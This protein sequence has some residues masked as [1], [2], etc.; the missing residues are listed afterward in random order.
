MVRS[1]SNSMRTIFRHSECLGA[2]HE[3][4]K[5]PAK[6]ISQRSHVVVGSSG[7]SISWIVV[8]GILIPVEREL[9]EP[10]KRILL[11]RECAGAADVVA[12]SYKPAPADTL[13]RPVTGS[14]QI[15]FPRKQ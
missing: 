1:A 13:A 5:A 14:V 10:Q 7:G 3:S 9:R 8:F 11:D 6:L 4:P 12:A 15:E 2:G